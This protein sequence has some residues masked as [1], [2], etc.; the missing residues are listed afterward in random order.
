MNQPAAMISTKPMILGMAENSSA[1]AA[2][3]EVN[4]ASLHSVTWT[5]MTEISKRDRCVDY[6]TLSPFRVAPLVGSVM[7]QL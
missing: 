7:R 2:A 1:I 5:G 3:S 6:S 4:M